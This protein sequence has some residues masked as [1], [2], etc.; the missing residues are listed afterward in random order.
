M[1]TGVLGHND[2]YGHYAP[3]TDV[4]NLSRVIYHME[5]DVRDE[6][7]K[8]ACHDPGGIVSREMAKSDIRRDVS[9][10]S[11]ATNVPRA[12]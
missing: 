12:P 11:T 8:I 1:V 10:M 6:R 5:F 4:K 7:K 2:Y 3:I 9:K